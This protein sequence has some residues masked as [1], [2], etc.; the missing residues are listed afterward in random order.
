MGFGL[1]HLGRGTALGLH[2]YQGVLMKLSRVRLLAAGVVLVGSAVLVPGA[3][4]SAPSGFA[5]TTLVTANLDHTVRINSDGV[6][7]QTK[8]PT[9]VRVQRVVVAAGGSSGWHHHPGVV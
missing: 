6:K 5:A 9:D 8:E 7:L 4:A 1:G 3:F 2:K